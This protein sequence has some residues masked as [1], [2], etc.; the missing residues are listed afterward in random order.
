[1]DLPHSPQAA[2]RIRV[3]TAADA[4]GVHAI[5]APVVRDTPISFETEVPDVAEMRSRILKTLP[6]FPWLVAEDGNGVAG[7]VYAGRYAE[8]AAY[9]WSATVSVYVHERWRGQ[10]LG[11]RLY[12]ELLQGLTDL[13]YCQAFAGITLPNAGSVALHE[14]VGFRPVGVYPNAGH[15]HGR[16][17]DVGWWQKPLQRPDPPPEPRPFGG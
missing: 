13:G 9:R 12:G 10:G 1:M 14:S 16:W 7:Y 3:A 11:R 15:K 17:H 5:Y 4:E 6:L 2:L 8:R